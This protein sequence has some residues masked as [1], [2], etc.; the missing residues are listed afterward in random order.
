MKKPKMTARCELRI[1][2][3]EKFTKKEKKEEP[4]L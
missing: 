1:F 4:H 3:G 2:L